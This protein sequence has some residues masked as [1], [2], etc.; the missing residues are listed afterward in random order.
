M[1][2]RNGGFPGLERLNG[3]VAAFDGRLSLPM[4]KMVK[5]NRAF[6]G[7]FGHRPTTSRMMGEDALGFQA[8][9]VGS[10]VVMLLGLY[11]AQAKGWVLRIAGITQVHS[12]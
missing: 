9:E 11:I 2:Q 1:H 8:I 4:E 3:G 10:K 7:P 5:K 6:T 12:L